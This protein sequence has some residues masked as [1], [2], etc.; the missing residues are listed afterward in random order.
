MLERAHCSRPPAAAAA[1]RCRLPPARLPPQSAA[2][3]LWPYPGQ[4]DVML[5]RQ[6]SNAVLQERG[7]LVHRRT[8]IAGGEGGARGC[9]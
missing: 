7:V 5:E 9:L 1:P 3:A 4:P 8:R 6:Q 2:P